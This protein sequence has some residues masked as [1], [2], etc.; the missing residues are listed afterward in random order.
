MSA[1][2]R[3]LRQEFRRLEN[4]VNEAFLEL[5][6][7]DMTDYICSKYGS[8]GEVKELFDFE[9]YETLIEEHNLLEHLVQVSDC[10]FVLGSIGNLLHMVSESGDTHFRRFDHVGGFRF[11]NINNRGVAECN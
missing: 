2:I 11:K 7:V 3:N 6:D 4:S 1:K 5:G 10:W 8:K 9:D